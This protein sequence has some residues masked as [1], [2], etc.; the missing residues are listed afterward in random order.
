LAE[1]VE[2]M[3]EVVLA[4]ERQVKDQIAAQAGAR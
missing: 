2:R 3:A 1:M 4:V